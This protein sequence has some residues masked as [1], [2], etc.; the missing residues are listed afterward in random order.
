M[1]EQMKKGRNNNVVEAEVLKKS[2]RLTL[3]VSFFTE[4]AEKKGS[5]LSS[6]FLPLWQLPNILNV[7]HSFSYSCH[8]C[9][10]IGSR[11]A[12]KIS[13]ATTAN[14]EEFN[15]EIM[16]FNY[17]PIFT[18][19]RCKYA[20]RLGNKQK[21]RWV[22]IV[23]ECHCAMVEWVLSFNT[24]VQKISTF[25]CDNVAKAHVKNERHDTKVAGCEIFLKI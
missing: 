7:S 14:S 5:E 13:P 10:L 18:Q 15:F 25:S 1:R 12:A 11:T 16:A 24:N 17:F 4:S 6:F 20:W 3:R 19:P 2:T 8:C 9:W 21:Q 22:E 23:F